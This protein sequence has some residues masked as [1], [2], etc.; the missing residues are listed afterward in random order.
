M[1]LEDGT[2]R[3][4]KIHYVCDGPVNSSLPVFILEGNNTQSHADFLVLQSLLAKKNRRSCI[5][6]KP[7]VGYS[8]YLLTDAVNA[9]ETVYHGFV[10]SLDEN[11][12]YAFVAWGTGGILD[13]FFFHF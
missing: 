12:P 2:G 11:P 4:Y 1:N 3:D 9:A 7:G 13:C 5:W 10:K 6:D 8:E